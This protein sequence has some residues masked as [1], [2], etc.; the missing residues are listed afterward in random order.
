M[1]PPAP[2]APRRRTRDSVGAVRALMLHGPGDLRLEEMPEPAAGPGEIVVSVDVALT[3][4]TDAKMARAGAHPALGPLPTGL[5]HE[6]VGTVTE[7]G[8][9]VRRPAVGDAVVVANSAPCG[10]CA[11]CAA[12]RASLCP[13][14]VYLTGAFAERVRV[15]ARIVARNVLPLPEGLAPEIAAMTEPLACAVHSAGR[16]VAGEGEVVLVLG[17]GV[18]GQL[19]AG[20]LAR[21]GCRVHLADPHPERRERAILFGAERAHPAPRDD[22][23]AA[24][25]RRR[26]PG[27]RGAALVVEAVGS[28][29]A[30]RAAVGTVRPGGEVVLHGGCPA[31]TEV[32][33]PT[34]P[35]HYE[36]LNLRGSY[37]HTPAAV[38]AALDLL[39]RGALPFAELLGPPVALADVP[40]LLAAEPGAKRPVVT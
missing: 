8:E 1:L 3:C 32:S 18:Q 38:R 26:L 34:G 15:P 30:W 27:G 12:G 19:L 31:G 5:G 24:E 40:A 29:Q 20:L 4:A 39:S 10:I 23:A 13:Q 21:R 17:G 36:E 25:L 28:P 16:C 11:D 33:L 37:H 22:A 14:I 35:L 7:A 2:A 6:L 9:G